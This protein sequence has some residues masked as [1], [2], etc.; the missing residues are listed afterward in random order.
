M[1]N[2][3]DANESAKNELQVDMS[4]VNKKDT[5][6]SLSMELSRIR[7]LSDFKFLALQH[8]RDN[9]QVECFYG[10]DFFTE[11]EEQLYDL[12][13]KSPNPIERKNIL[14]KLTRNKN[15][16]NTM[17][18]ERDVLLYHLM[19]FAADEDFDKAIT[20]GVDTTTFEYQNRFNYWISLFEAQFGDILVFAQAIEGSE[21]EKI[22]LINN[23]II[24]LI[25]QQNEQNNSK[26]T[27]I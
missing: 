1:G 6:R 20:R 15:R 19:P 2:F 7:N 11:T 18:M 22:L 16:F 13:D 4:F 3:S 12:F 10:S 17:K 24:N 5:L 8:G 26:N 23:L 9:I 14:I 25:T 21:S 27:N